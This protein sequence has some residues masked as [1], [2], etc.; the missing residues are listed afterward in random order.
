MD[1]I[2]Q[3]AY[4]NISATCASS[5]LEPLFSTRTPQL[6]LPHDRLSA[7]STTVCNRYTFYD[8]VSVSL[9]DE[10]LYQRAWVFQ[11]R[12][13][14]SRNV[15]FTGSQI[16][17]ECAEELSCESSHA[18]GV[19]NV[20]H[21]SHNSV[22]YKVSRSN[23]DHSTFDPPEGIFSMKTLSHYDQLTS[24]QFWYQLIKPYASMNLTH[25]GDRLIAISG[26]A[27][28][29]YIN[30][31]TKYYAGIWAGNIRHGLC[32]HYRERG[33]R[34]E[35][36]HRPP[37]WSWASV[38]S[39]GLSFPTIDLDQPVLEPLYYVT[40]VHTPTL[41]DD[42]FGHVHDAK[43]CLRG[44]LFHFRDTTTLVEGRKGKLSGA[45]NLTWIQIPCALTP[46]GPGKHGYVAAEIWYDEDNIMS[47]DQATQPIFALPLLISRTQLLSSRTA[48]CFTLHFLLLIP[49]EDASGLYRRIGMCNIEVPDEI[50][51]SPNEG[52]KKWEPLFYEPISDPQTYFKGEL[53]I[54]NTLTKRYLPHYEGGG[55]VYQWVRRLLVRL[56][57]HGDDIPCVRRE[58]DGQHLFIVE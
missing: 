39:K 26:L 2:Y 50:H 8:S 27:R 34:L 18:M 19:P 41:K 22:R 40:E 44:T 49:M 21:V 6:L 25:E 54:V 4:I 23:D 58:P 52:L 7:G 20:Y 10:P 51:L 14:A 17:Y 55:R 37:T 42:M 45:F 43:I 38:R 53:P 30:I 56:R 12:C 1:S 47:L 46:F 13:L 24:L 15:S 29:F 57:T 33:R 11:E 48:Y 28:R 9:D 32:W 3:H 36:P 31:Q 35:V 5:C 16:H